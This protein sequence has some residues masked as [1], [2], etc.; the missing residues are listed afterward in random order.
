MFMLPEA[1]DAQLDLMLRYYPDDAP[2][3][4]PF[5]T[6]YRNMLSAQ[7]KRVAAI[8]GDVVFHAPRR[9]FLKNVANKQKAWSF[10]KQTS[11]SLAI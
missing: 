9:F 10:S 5:D 8:Q 11:L 6:G 1:T 2:S 4:C 3:G 7:S